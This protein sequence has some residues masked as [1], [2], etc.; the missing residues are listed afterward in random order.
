MAQMDD[1]LKSLAALR[2]GIS[3]GEDPDVLLLRVELL[4]STIPREA[5]RAHSEGI[6]Q[7]RAETPGEVRIRERDETMA[8]IN[9]AGIE[10]AINNAMRTT[11]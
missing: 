2:E 8:A 1:S 9:E 11:E 5:A 10:R 7:G 3:S 6:W 4:E